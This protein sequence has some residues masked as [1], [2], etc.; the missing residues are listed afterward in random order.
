MNNNAR[1]IT[2]H[3]IA[4][5]GMMSALVFASNYIQFYIATPAG[6]TRV[7]IANG[8]CLLGA[9]LFGKLRGGLSAGLGSF[10][11]DLTF[12]EYVPTSWVTFINKFI[13]AFLAGWIAQRGAKS[14]DPK[15]RKIYAAIGAVV[16]A[17]TYVVLYLGTSFIK[18]FYV[19][20]NPIETVLA[21]IPIKLGA[22]MVNA[23][24]AVLL[25][26]LLS[27]V[28]RPAFQRAGLAEKL[29]IR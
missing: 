6:T 11:Y 14:G 10:L 17:L 12:A 25:S 21:T 3:D 23:V 19:R 5:V 22:S 26:T 29:R 2:V 20:G 13:M 15:K 28:L 27:T 1:K 7:H 18:E 16:G 9:L 8:V 4:V 24:V